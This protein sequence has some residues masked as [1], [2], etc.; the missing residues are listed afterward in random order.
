M[1]VVQADRKLN[2]PGEA[3][4]NVLSARAFV[5]WYNGHPNFTGLNPALDCEDALIVGNGNV[6]LDCA[7]ILCKTPQELQHTD[8]ARHAVA[9]LGKRC[10]SPPP[11]SPAC[12]PRPH[13]PLLRAA[14]TLSG[15]TSLVAAVTFSRPS[16]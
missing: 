10:G 6:A 7:R 5:N 1:A 4:K 16:P 3:L 14:V 9:A 15:F 13:H 8:I 12:P 11:P 2:I